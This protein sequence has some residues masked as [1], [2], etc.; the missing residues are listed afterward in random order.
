MHYLK[1]LNKYTIPLQHYLSKSN[2]NEFYDISFDDITTTTF[3]ILIDKSTI[4][5]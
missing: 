3:D 2:H 1:L 5:P 4:K